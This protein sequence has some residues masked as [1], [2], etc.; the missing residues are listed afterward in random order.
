MLHHLL[1]KLHLYNYEKLLKLLLKLKNRKKEE[2]KLLMSIES[3]YHFKRAIAT[4]F[5]VR[6][7]YI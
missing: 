6:R 7:V 1:S 4:Y 2:R 3:N 5:G